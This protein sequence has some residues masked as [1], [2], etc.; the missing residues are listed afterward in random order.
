[1]ETLLNE[2]AFLPPAEPRPNFL[3]SAEP[4][5]IIAPMT[6]GI[7]VI[8]EEGKAIVMAADRLITVGEASLVT[9]VAHPKLKQLSPNL[10]L[11][12]TGSVQQYEYAL[13]RFEGVS[14]LVRGNSI[15]RIA[16]RFRKACHRI[17][18]KIL[19]YR[20]TEANLGITYEDFSKQCMDN[21]TTNIM[22]DIYNKM[23]AHP[24][25]MLVLMAGIDDR[26]PHIY[27]INDMTINSFKAMGYA[28]IGIGAVS[29][30]V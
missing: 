3:R 30:T 1:M 28:A 26:G 10:W 2:P 24:F 19:Q 25:D 17:R 21:P 20:F 8:C 13:E 5:P 29:A 9:E 11:T 27:L 12:I 16:R 7:A 14:Q 15:H 18:A 22:S 6:V 4:T 23:L